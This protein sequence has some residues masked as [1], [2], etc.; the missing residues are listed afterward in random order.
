LLKIPFRTVDEEKMHKVLA[1]EADVL[2]IA[3]LTD[4][5]KLLK[6]EAAVTRLSV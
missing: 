2:K 1:Q 3:K 6:L 5:D 4:T